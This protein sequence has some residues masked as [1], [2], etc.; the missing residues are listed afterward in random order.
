VGCFLQPLAGVFCMNTLSIHGFSATKLD[1]CHALHHVC[2]MCRASPHAAL[3][4]TSALR[5]LNQNNTI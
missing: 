5:R 4:C 3:A 1:C 2:S